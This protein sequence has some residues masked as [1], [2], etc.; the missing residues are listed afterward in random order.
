MV[1]WELV[2]GDLVGE[3]SEGEGEGRWEV[4]FKGRFTEGCLWKCLNWDAGKVL[5]GGL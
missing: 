4:R 5:F 1:K 3:I 2:R